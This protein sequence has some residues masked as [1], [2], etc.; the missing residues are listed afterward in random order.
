MIGSDFEL[1]VTNQTGG[2]VPVFGLVGGTKDKPVPTPFGALQ[3]DNVMAE[4]NTVPVRTPKEF[5]VSV[6]L[7]MGPLV[8]RL[9]PQGLGYVAKDEHD[10]G[11]IMQEVRLPKKFNLQYRSMGCAPDMHY[12]RGIANDNVLSEDIGD[13]R[14]CGFHLHLSDVTPEIIPYMDLYLGLRQFRDNNGYTYRQNFYGRLGS[15]RPTQYGNSAG[16]EYRVLGSGWAWNNLASIEEGLESALY[17]AKVEV[18]ISKKDHER[19]AL[20]AHTFGPISPD[21]EKE[22]AEVLWGR[23][24]A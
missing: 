6:S 7:A 4:V 15:Y 21:E 13:H 17:S 22:I 23:Y 24:C 10:F 20:L 8:D 5:G 3:E 18:P 2:V 11:P 16:I 9:E 1:F 14:F 12:Y 19:L